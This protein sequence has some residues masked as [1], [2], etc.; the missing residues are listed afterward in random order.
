MYLSKLVS[1]SGYLG[2]NFLTISRPGKWHRCNM[3]IYFPCHFITC[4]DLCNHITTKRQSFHATEMKNL[5]SHT[6]LFLSALGK[7]LFSISLFIFIIL[8]MLHK[9]NHSVK[10][11]IVYGIFCGINFFFTWYNALESHSSCCIHACMRAKSL[12][13]CPTLCNPMDHI[14]TGSSVHGILQARILEWV[15]M[16]SFRGSSW[17]RDQTHISCIFC[18]AG[19]FFTHWAIRKAQ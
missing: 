13:L 5:C 19:R 17:P 3:C 4:T 7:Q 16:P 12:Q 14:P 2:H 6:L 9:R 11:I 8:R 1:S 15:A 10:E 18:I